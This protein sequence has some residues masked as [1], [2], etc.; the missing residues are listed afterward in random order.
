VGAV[1][2]YTVGLFSCFHPSFSDPALG[3][4]L[5]VLEFVVDP[6]SPTLLFADGGDSGAVVVSRSPRSFGA[7]VG[8]LFARSPDKTRGLV[9]PFQ[10]IQAKA[11]LDVA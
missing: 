7:V 5:N 2:G 3:T 4:L 11:D 10:Y 9:V 8:I 6:E 1:T